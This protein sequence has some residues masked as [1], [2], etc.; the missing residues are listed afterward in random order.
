MAVRIT[1]VPGARLEHGRPLVFPESAL[2]RRY[3]Q[4]RG[5]ELGAAAHNP[6]NL[7]DC[8]NVAPDDG[9]LEFYRASQAAMCG[10]FA[11]VDLWGLAGAI[12]LPDSSL[13]YVVSS[14]VIEHCAD[15]V[16]A[17]L[18]W[19][20]VLKPGGIVFMI[21]PKR[22]ALPADQGRPV[23]EVSAMVAAHLERDRARPRDEAHGGD[24]GHVF[25][26]T[27]GTMLDLILIANRRFGLEWTVL[28]A[29]ETDDKVGNGHTV[30]A[31][32]K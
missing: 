15:P 20:R 23:S 12:P 22:D 6:F 18:E 5:V 13:D 29:Q 30:V 16:G 9:N 4:G 2:A 14:H 8:L 1:P 27:L 19:N 24:Q 31:R 25:V 28:E 7:P 21:F 3:C 17:F 11:E 26:Y 32:Y 10:A